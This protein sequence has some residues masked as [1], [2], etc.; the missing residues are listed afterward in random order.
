MG[1]GAGIEYLAPGA[2]AF[3]QAGETQQA[4]EALGRLL[5]PDGLGSRHDAVV[6]FAL[7]LAAEAAFALNATEYAADLAS[8]IEPLRH[9]HVTLNVWGGGGFYWGSLRHGYGL[10]LALLGRSDDA[11]T[12]LTQ[13][14]TDQ[15]A[16][17]ATLFAERSQQVLRSLGQ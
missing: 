9:T 6:P 1:P 2:L 7:A 16:A 10:V 11:A 17:G 4:T 12:A 8:R 3:A 14:A 5:M 15:A 13:A